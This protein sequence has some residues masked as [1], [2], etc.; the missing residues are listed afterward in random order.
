MFVLHYCFD[1]LTGLPLYLKKDS[2]TITLD[3]DEALKFETEEECYR[4]KL[5]V[6]YADSFR[7]WERNGGF[8]L[9]DYVEFHKLSRVYVDEE[10]KDVPF[11]IIKE[12]YGNKVIKNVFNYENKNFIIL[13]F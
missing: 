7:V 6:D 5:D 1:H 9:N 11:D 2:V 3:Y 12:K 10:K 4:A 8:T 13:K